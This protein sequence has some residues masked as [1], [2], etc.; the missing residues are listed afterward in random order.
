VI[1]YR[2]Q[3]RRVPTAEVLRR[4]GEARGFEREMEM[5]ELRAGVADAFCPDCDRDISNAALPPEIEI[6]V[7]EGFAYYSLDPELYR[8]AARQFAAAATPSSVAVIGIRSIGATLGAIVQDE[9]RSA[10]IAT[11]FTTVRPR[12]HA[13][14]RQLRVDYDLAHA[15]LGWSGHF[16]IVDE[17]P[18]LSGTSFASVSE[19][20]GTLGIRDD[21]IVLF[22]S[23][24]ADPAAFRSDRGRRC[25]DRHRR[26]TAD[27]DELHRFDDAEDLS[28]GRWRER[29]GIRPAVQPQHERRKYLRG[30]RLYKFAGLGRYGR[31]KLER[32]QRLNGYLPETLGLE[33]GFLVTRWVEGRAVRLSAALVDHVAGYLAEVSKEFATG[34]AAPAEPLA[35]M[36]E[37]NTGRAWNG[38]LPA[39]GAAVLLDGRM[40]RHEWLETPA[41]FVKTDALD[42]HDDHFFPGP[43]DIAWDLA[44]FGV[45]FGGEEQLVARYVERSGDR[46]VAA[47]MPFYRA[48]YLAFR[49]GYCHMAVESLG[50]HEDAARFRRDLDRY[51]ARI[52]SEAWTTKTSRLSV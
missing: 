3:R 47:R 5:G 23:W 48:A 41:G 43:Q 17:G 14:D 8:M 24:N 40:L 30:D 49:F 45:E 51:D 1:V 52:R 44:A 7:P 12:G 38:P 36:I 29:R 22:P 33:D 25:W 16:A 35:H 10:G 39:P 31:T 19:F 37:M 42:H 28:G 26:Y 32:A 50:D 18:G 9:L 2:E 46:D 11:R 4:I 6:S 15:W 27:F 34:E 20:L 21:R 13:F